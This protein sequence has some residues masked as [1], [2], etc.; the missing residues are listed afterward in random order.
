MSDKETNFLTNPDNRR[1]IYAFTL[2][3]CVLG[4]AAIGLMSIWNVGISESLTFK[5]IISFITVGVL[6]VFLY[7]LTYRHGEKKVRTLGFVTGICAIAFAGIA[8]MQLWFSAFEKVFFGQLSVTLVIVG[9]IAAFF[10][11]VF[12]D[13]FENKKM[14]DENY[15]D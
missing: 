11:A 8:M 14:K 2:L 7:T 9:L 3:G 13:F 15:L 1:K 4:I 6:S 10:I 5:S 12:D